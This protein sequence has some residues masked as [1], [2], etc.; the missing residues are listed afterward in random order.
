MGLRRIRL[1]RVRWAVQRWVGLG[2]GRSP[3]GAGHWRASLTETVGWWHGAGQARQYSGGADLPTSQQVG[4]GRTI[5]DRFPNVRPPHGWET[6]RVLCGQFLDEY[7]QLLESPDGGG[8]R[9]GARGAFDGDE[10]WDASFGS[11]GGGD[12][13]GGPSGGGMQGPSGGG[14]QGPSGGGTQDPLGGGMGGPSDRQI[15][16]AER[17]VATLNVYP[18]EGWREDVSLCREFLDQYAP[19]MDQTPSPGQLGA[20]RAIM[21]QGIANPPA[22][23]ERDRRLCSEFLD[24]HF[25]SLPK[26]GDGASSAGVA[27]GPSEKQVAFAQKIVMALNIAS[28]PEGLYTDRAVCKKF[29]DDHVDLLPPSDKQIKL[30]EILADEC[31]VRLTDKERSS[32]KRISEFIDR[33]ARRGNPAQLSAQD[34]QQF[35]EQHGQPTS[36]PSQSPR[37]NSYG[38]SSGNDPY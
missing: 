38:R 28:P 3:S 6:D 30:A 10:R 4:L 5:L 7:G 18:P 8:R 19:Q 22:G 25:S 20:V 26:R 14:M 15:A 32:S 9:A 31:G 21:V 37:Y 34:A 29:L 33:H 36:D 12:R 11:D 2:E 24:L 1:G 27:S 35:R 23:W 16:F 13:G 17:I